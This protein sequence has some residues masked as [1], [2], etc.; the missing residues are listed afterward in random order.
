M[1]LLVFWLLNSFSLL[2]KDGP[3]AI[4]AGAGYNF[5]LRGW[6]PLLTALC[7]VVEHTDNETGLIRLH[8]AHTYLH[9]HTHI[10]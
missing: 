1:D 3:I 2:F 7:P 8:F 4:D 10:T 5:N 9:T 6:D